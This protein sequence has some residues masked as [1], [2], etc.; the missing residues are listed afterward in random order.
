MDF[1]TAIA[2]YQQIAQSTVHIEYEITLRYGVQHPSVPL[3]RERLRELGDLVAEH[4]SDIYD[5]IME[6]SVRKFQARNTLLVD[7]I[8][9]KQ[10]FNFLNTALPDQVKALI[11]S[12]KK[13]EAIPKTTG[14]KIIINIPG[15][16]CWLYENETFLLKTNCV[17]GRPDRQTVEFDDKIEYADF[18]PYW[19]VPYSIF[20]KDKLPKI[21]KYGPKYL[22]DN[23]FKVI[24]NNGRIVNPYSLNWNSYR[25][26][27]FPYKLRQ[28]PGEWN[29]LG[30]VKYM[31]P[32]SYSIYMH[33]TPSKELFQRDNRA[34]S[35]GC[36]RLS[37]PAMMGAFLLG[38]P[39]QE[40]ISM[41][42]DKNQNNKIVRLAEHIPIHITYMTSW[43]EQDST[44]RFAPDVY[45]KTPMLT[46][47]YVLGDNGVRPVKKAA[48]G[49][50][51]NLK[52]IKNND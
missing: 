21:L 41:M 34:Y 18:R 35:S 20:K 4:T 17:V 12:K 46:D 25:N 13:W 30:L 3:I 24:D 38:I 32:N 22:T 15:Y 19:N 45:N 10:T 40:V 31:F 48:L 43:I 23:H 1:D 52:V 47:N 36:I 7:G 49:E 6:D 29:A 16:E 33:D 5:N 39:E 2:E 8:A 9:G 37:D 26:N 50:P 42:L 11:L 27:S 14:K 44:V 28:D 51:L